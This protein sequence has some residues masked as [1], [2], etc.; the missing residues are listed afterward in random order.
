MMQECNAHIRLQMQQLAD[1]QAVEATAFLE[2]VQPSQRQMCHCLSAML[3]GS[4][5]DR[6][7]V[8]REASTACAP[9]THHAPSCMGGLNSPCTPCDGTC[10]AAHPQ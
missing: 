5:F 10:H 9:V 7:T 1:S 3:A 2:Q 8:R 6:I 4:P